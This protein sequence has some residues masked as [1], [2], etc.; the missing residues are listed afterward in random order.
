VSTPTGEDWFLHF[1]DKGVFGRVVHLQPMSFKNDWPVI[2]IDPDRDGKGEPVMTYKKPKSA[3]PAVI[4]T[5]Q[6]T[7]EFN[8]WIW[9]YNGSG[10][11]IQNRHGR[12][13]ILVKVISI[14]F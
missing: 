12:L 7:D 6:D 3:L 14:I 13:C 1:Q 2:G 10:M 11:P 5:P 8:S 9:V 4:E